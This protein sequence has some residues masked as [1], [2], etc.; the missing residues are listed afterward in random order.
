MTVT[1]QKRWSIVT[2]KNDGWTHKAI[3]KKLGISNRE[4]LLWWSRF[5]ATGDVKNSSKSG[6]PKITSEATDQEIINKA[7]TDDGNTSNQI[8][9]SLTTTNTSPSRHTISRR[10]KEVGSTYKFPGKKPVLSEKN[11]KKGLEWSKNL[12]DH[13]FTRTV[14]SDEKVFYLDK[15][16]GRVCCVPGGYNVRRTRKS[17]VKL[18]VWGAITRSF[19]SPLKTI[20]SKLN[21]RG[22]QKILKEEL[23]P[24]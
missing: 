4:I 19:K 23:M 8:K 1:K 7:K 20:S 16:D 2:Y 21:T 6:R 14:I 15:R 12:L 17:T 18:H 22:Y 24:F 5:C 11:R 10:L 13:D 3:K 9:S